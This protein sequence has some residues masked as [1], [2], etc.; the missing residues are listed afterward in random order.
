MKILLGGITCL[1]AVAVCAQSSMERLRFDAM[2]RPYALLMRGDIQTELKFTEDQVKQYKDVRHSIEID[3]RNN[4]AAEGSN[5]TSLLDENDGKVMPILTKEQKARL[6]ELRIQIVG[7]TILADPAVAKT[8]QLNDQQRQAVEQIRNEAIDNFF[9]TIRAGNKENRG[10]ALERISK[11]EEKDL[12][13]ILFD[14]Q[15]D[16]LY[17]MTGTPYANARMKGQFPL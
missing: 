5:F 13:S 8:L 17:K 2:G 12:M 9:T 14:G 7:P 1:L 6:L 10:A 3:N 16:K 4:G 11:K 15:R